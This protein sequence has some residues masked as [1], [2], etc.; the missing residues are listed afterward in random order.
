MKA[1]GY[2]QSLAIQENDA[3]LDLELPEPVPGPRDLLVEIKAIA[4]NPVDTKIRKR[5]LPAAGEVK[6]LGWDACGVVKAIGNEVTLFRPGDEVWY[7]GA[8]D[9][10]GCNAE[11]HLVDERIA[12]KKP[13]S[14][15]FAEAA[16]LPL[17]TIT[18]WE[19]LFD[20]LAIARNNKKNDSQLLI[21]GAAGGVGSILTQLAH[22]LTG[23]SVIGTASRQQTRDWVTSLGANHV[24]DHSQSLPTQLKSIGINSVS[25]V[26][27][28]THTDNHF[29]D[30]AHI[31]APQGKLGL[32]DDPERL[33]IGLLKQ[34]SISLHWEFMYTRSLYATADMI[35]QHEL[36]TEVA[37]LVDAGI[38]RT[39]M[40]EHFGKIN[41]SNLKRAHAFIES[42]QA[43][44][45]VVLEEF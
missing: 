22:R 32:I 45:K 2:K 42:E 15:S 12:A 14:L 11:L 35:R 31:L 20:R 40:S 24:I 26:A 23:A 25:H 30:I 7:A 10:P 41:A 37:E 6:I 19:L 28:L 44:G 17:T 29:E 39:T 8:I 5:Y 4:V 43:C 21:I 33:D 13:R 3:L 36:L 18:A 1:V 27:S 38:I 16:A 34:K 9:R